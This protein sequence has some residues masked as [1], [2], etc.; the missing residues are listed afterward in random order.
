MSIRLFGFEVIDFISNPLFGP[1]STSVA[2]PFY[3]VFIEYDVKILE[4][5]PK[6]EFL[7]WWLKFW[8]LSINTPK[9]K[10]LHDYECYNL[11]IPFRKNL[12]AGTWNVPKL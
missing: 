4:Y 3:E 11:T 8:K 10:K 7:Y 12:L 6:I 1:C 5:L 9:K 2:Q